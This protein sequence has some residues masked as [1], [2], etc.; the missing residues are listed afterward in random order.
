[1]SNDSDM[2]NTSPK[3]PQSKSELRMNNT[4]WQDIEMTIP[5]TKDGDPV[6]V[7]L[8]DTKLVQTNASHRP[9]FKA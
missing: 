5:C 8:A 9:T 4:A 3:A 6:A 2:P 7:W 1:M